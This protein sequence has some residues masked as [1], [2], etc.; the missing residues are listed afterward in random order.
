MLQ[1]G[2]VTLGQVLRDEAISE[3][4]QHLQNHSSPI[5]SNAQEQRRH[6]VVQTAACSTAATSFLSQ[7]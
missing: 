6:A 3:Q 4:L 1:R 5:G 7:Q 2:A